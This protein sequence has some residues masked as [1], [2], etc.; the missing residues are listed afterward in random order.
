MTD[1]ELAKAKE[2]QAEQK[3]KGGLIWKL[4]AAASTKLSLFTIP[5]SMNRQLKAS[6]R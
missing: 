2:S 5:D 1:E 3:K 4:S 6:R